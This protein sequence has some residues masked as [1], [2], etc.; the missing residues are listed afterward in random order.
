MKQFIHTPHRYLHFLS[1]TLTLLF[2]STLHPQ[3]VHAQAIISEVYPA[4]A[5]GEP[6]WVEIFNPTDTPITLSGW[7]LQDK[8]STPS[9]I[10]IFTTQIL[11]AKSFL[12]LD[13]STSKLNNTGDGV[14]LYSSTNQ[15]ID[16][17][18]Y[19]SSETAK[20]WTRTGL[21]TSVFILGIPTKSADSPSYPLYT[22]PTPLPTESPTPTSSPLP[23]ATPTPTVTPVATATPEPTPIAT[24][25]PIPSPTPTATP[26]PTPTPSTTPSPTPNPTT[27]PVSTPSYDPLLITLTEVMACPAGGLEWI[28]LYNSDTSD[29]ALENWKIIDESSNSRTFSGIIPAHE[30]HIF[31]WSG[32]ML[33]NAGDSLT[34]T[35]AT[36]TIIAQLGYESYTSG[37][38]QNVINTA[39]GIESYS[40]AAT[41][42]LPNTPQAVESPLP[43]PTATPTPTAAPKKSATPT[44]SAPAA[45]KQTAT[46]GS[47]NIP[48]SPVPPFTIHWPQVLGVSTTATESAGGH[49]NTDTEVPRVLAPAAAPSTPLIS[50]I[51]SGVLTT[52]SSLWILYGKKLLEILHNS[53]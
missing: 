48:R 20:S 4:P 31:P 51:L 30:Y 14:T 47:K 53:A 29:H 3:A 44:P 38:S 25:T 21:Q 6:E 34:I 10:F 18:D 8:L 35:T 16:T 52:T 36:G 24:S 45:A 42:G 27:S 43:T 49:S 11:E 12:S 17:M 37:H 22:A 7:K 1:I 46:A 19:T 15:V 9:D 23:T 50:G 39:A 41:P 32:S 13:L 26:L 2:L 5:S 33:N 40:A 28:E